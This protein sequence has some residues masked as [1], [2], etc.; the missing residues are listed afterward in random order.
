MQRVDLYALLLIAILVGA[1][2][3]F[4]AMGDREMAMLFGGGAIGLATPLIKLL[5]GKE[6]GNGQ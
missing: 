2:L 6:N 4:R 5:K 3:A 1:A